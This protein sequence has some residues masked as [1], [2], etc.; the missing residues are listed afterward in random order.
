MTDAEYVLLASLFIALAIAIR[1]FVRH[2]AEWVARDLQSADL[3]A[4]AAVAG[5]KQFGVGRKQMFRLSRRGFV[6]ED[7]WGGCRITLKGRYAAY[8]ARGRRRAAYGDGQGSDHG[9]D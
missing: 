5:G 1:F 3:Q 7:V 8:L 6:S 2:D 9:R 4:L